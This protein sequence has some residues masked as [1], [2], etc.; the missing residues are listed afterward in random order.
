MAKAGGK[1]SKR[2]RAASRREAAL[3]IRFTDLPTGIPLAW[4]LSRHEDATVLL[5]P[6]AA[7][8]RRLWGLCTDLERRD[9]YLTWRPTPTADREVL[10]PDRC[11]DLK[12]PSPG[13]A[14]NLPSPGLDTLILD[15]RELRDVLIHLAPVLSGQ[16]EVS[17]PSRYAPKKLHI[18]VEAWLAERQAEGKQ[19]PTERDCRTWAGKRGY[20][21]NAVW[22]AVRPPN[23]PRGRRPHAS[24]SP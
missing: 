14:P 7:I 22:Q 16:Q 6:W 20:T 13:K 10:A 19:P 3:P 8:E 1:H 23:P 24:K 4:A 12:L 2:R 5:D 11:R 17:Q 18:D 21:Q 15:G 9:C